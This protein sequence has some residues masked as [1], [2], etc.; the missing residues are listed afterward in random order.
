M[1]FDSDREKL[2][3]FFRHVAGNSRVDAIENQSD[4]YNELR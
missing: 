1:I 2:L 3:N 4:G